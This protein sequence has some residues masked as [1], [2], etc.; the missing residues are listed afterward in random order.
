MTARSDGHL[1]S[2]FSPI[3]TEG[4]TRRIAAD[5]LPLTASCSVLSS[6]VWLPTPFSSSPASGLVATDTSGSRRRGADEA[7]SLCLIVS[8]KRAA[9][10]DIVL[11]CSSNGAKVTVLDLA[12]KPN[13]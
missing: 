5:V 11:S 13:S 1:I 6:V 2:I 9:D 4:G 8:S 7:S 10:D 3:Y 12:P